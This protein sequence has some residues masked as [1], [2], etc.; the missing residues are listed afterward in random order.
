VPGPQGHPQSGSVSACSSASTGAPAKAWA[1]PVSERLAFHAV[2]GLSLRLFATHILPLPLPSGRAPLEQVGDTQRVL[3]GLLLERNGAKG[4]HGVVLTSAP[5]LVIF[6]GTALHW[7]GRRTLLG[8]ARE[9]ERLCL[10]T[11]PTER[12]HC[13]LWFLEEGSQPAQSGG[14][15]V[16]GCEEMLTPDDYFYIMLIRPRASTSLFLIKTYVGQPSTSVRLRCAT[17]GRRI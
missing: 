13:G 16:K 7:T 15:L 5:R 14:L 8:I 12:A 3:V 6:A 4:T 10:A 1:S 11:V 17:P 9:G 2:C